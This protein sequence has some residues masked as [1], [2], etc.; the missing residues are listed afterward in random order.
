MERYSICGV[1][2]IFLSFFSQKVKKFPD[3]PRFENGFWNPQILP[4]AGH[5]INTQ[6]LSI[7]VI[8]FYI[9]PWK[10][11]TF[12]FT[13]IL[14]QQWPTTQS[15]PGFPSTTPPRTPKSERDVS[16][17]RCRPSRP[18]SSPNRPQHPIGFKTFFLFSLYLFI[19]HKCRFYLAA[20]SWY[21][22]R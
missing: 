7:L 5:L 22:H 17:Q 14:T 9:A 10:R 20:I 18:G 15:P 21:I 1:I 2:R 3:F 13:T 6:L 8:H 4:D 11:F 19:Q 16:R 12:Y